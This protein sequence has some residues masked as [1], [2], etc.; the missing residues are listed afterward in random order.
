MEQTLTAYAPQVRSIVR[1]VAALLFLEHGTSGLFGWPSPLPAPPLFSLYW[2][3]GSIELV[4]GALLA[5]GLFSR[6][7]AFVMSGEM[8]FAYFI[9]HAP[10]GFFPILNRGDAAILFCFIFLY[11]VFA[12]PGPWSLDAV[13]RKRV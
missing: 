9:G 10:Q 13:W 8:A 5:L 4:G 12:G 1:I 6:P 11:F 3:S 7:A 2:C